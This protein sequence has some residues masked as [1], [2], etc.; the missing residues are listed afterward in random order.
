MPNSSNLS[1]LAELLGGLPI[2]GCLEGSPAAVAGVRC[3]DIL[4]S[5]NGKPTSTW[6]EFIEARRENQGWMVARIFRDG[7]VIEFAIETRPSSKSPMEIM[8]EVLGHPAVV[9]SAAAGDAN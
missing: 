4:L 1:R 7:S 9:D 2:L 3:G 8:G 6:T 5:I